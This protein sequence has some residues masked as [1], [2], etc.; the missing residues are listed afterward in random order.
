[1]PLLLASVSHKYLLR[2]VALSL[3]LFTTAWSIGSLHYSFPNL[4]QKGLTGRALV[5]I[6]QISLHHSLFGTRWVYRCQLKRFYPETEVLS[7]VSSLPCSILLPSLYTRGEP[8]PPGNCDYWVTGALTQGP[9]DDYRL[10]VKA[11]TPWIAIPG[12]WSWA[13]S[14]HQWKQ[15]LHDWIA[16]H[17]SDRLNASFLSGLA[18][19]EFDNP[20]M[21]GQFSRFG[22]QHLLAISGFHFAIVA[23]FLDFGLRLFMPRPLRFITLLLC[24]TTYCFFL[25]PQA[26]IVRA[27]IM[28]SST[29]IGG[30]IHKQATALNTLGLALLIVLGYNPLL[31]QELSFQLSFAATAAILFFYRPVHAYLCSLWPKR[32]LSEVIQMNAW[33]QHGYCILAFFRQGLAL[34]LAVNILALP[35]TLYYFQQFPWMGFLYNLFFP[36]LSSGSMCLLIL[37]GI[38]SFVPFLADKIH[39]V[40]ETYT[41]ALLR[42]VH[43]IPPNIDHYLTTEF[44]SPLWIVLYFCFAGLAGILW[45]QRASSEEGDF[46]FI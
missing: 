20:W 4:P 15:N 3:L 42:L 46:S 28:C 19:G 40:N 29:V 7:I 30:L 41:T 27:W 36:F 24:L 13:E 37:G 22:L 39:Q 12:S 23:A 2:R 14:R 33:H 38:C 26:S 9:Q 18:T 31:C 43:Q 32:S 44:F 34:G 45:K 21:R 35:L 1:M 8:R 16:S 11:L 5:H 6:D 25:G 17:F 10:K